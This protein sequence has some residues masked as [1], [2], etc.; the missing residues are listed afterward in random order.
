MTSAR[1]SL[2]LTLAR[3]ALGLLLLSGCRGKSGYPID[4]VVVFVKENHTFDNYFGAFPGADGVTTCKLKDGTAFAC[5][6]APRNTPRDLCHGHDCGL[7]AWAGGQMNGWED[8][9]GSDVNGDRLAWAQYGEEDIPNYWKYARTFALGDRYFSN[10]LGPSFPGHAFLLAA[11][12]GWAL[13][14]PP[15]HIPKSL[16]WGCDQPAADRVTV[17]QGGTCTTA[18]V[19]PCFDF[20]SVP[21]VLPPGVT[22][23]F[24]GTDFYGLDPIVWTMFDAMKSVRNGDGWKNVVNVSQ[25]ARDV[26]NGT[27][28]N[29]SWVVDQDLNDEHPAVGDICTGENWT[30]DHINLLMKSP[31]WS[32]TAILYTTDDSGGWVDHVAP[33]RQ[34]G[35]DAAHPYGLGFRLPLILI[36]PYARPGFVFHEQAEQASVPRFIERIFGAPA[37]STR[38]PAAQDGQANDLFGAFDFNQKPLPPL[39]LELRN[40]N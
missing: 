23:K 21:D 34:Y 17:L 35:C 36:S 29:V 9:G 15:T 19:A 20:P 4:H 38:D 33:P 14:N 7:T 1:P 18:A 8:V 12:A 32:H 37:L 13:G 2:R 28:P 27:L 10:M 3:C 40:C 16:N 25:F 22:W 31:Y 26:A 39:P 11:Q 24:Y 5:P 30:V 6:R